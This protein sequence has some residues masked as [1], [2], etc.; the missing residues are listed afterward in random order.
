MYVC[1]YP[2]EEPNSIRGRKP[3]NWCGALLFPYEMKRYGT[4]NT[5]YTWGGISGICCRQGKTAH[6]PMWAK[7]IEGSPAR[8][9]LDVWEDDGDNGRTL[10]QYSRQV[11]INSL[12]LYP[13]MF[14]R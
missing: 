3:C 1:I 11:I 9:I 7:P 6:L 12:R 10:R 2:E 13:V 4:R 5:G 8:E 14:E